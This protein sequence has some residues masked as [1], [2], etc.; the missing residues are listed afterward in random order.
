MPG[1]WRQ[2]YFSK[3][4]RGLIFGRRRPADGP[5]EGGETMM[6]MRRNVAQVGEFFS[7]LDAR[8]EHGMGLT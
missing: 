3:S 7:R 2:I 8:L 5:G 1:K 6:A 4:E